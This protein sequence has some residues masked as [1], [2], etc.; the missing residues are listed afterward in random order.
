MTVTLGDPEYGF[1]LKIRYRESHCS[2]NRVSACEIASRLGM[3]SR[4]T[5]EGCLGGSKHLERADES[6][7]KSQTHSGRRRCPISIALRKLCLLAP[8]WFIS[9]R[10]FSEIVV[11]DRSAVFD[12]LFRMRLSG[13]DFASAPFCGG[14]AIGGRH[15]CIVE[16]K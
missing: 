7:L 3:L 4:P 13:S 16:H 14:S 5:W 10:S 2:H 1:E 6:S 8:S 12:F 11:R 15:I 9:E